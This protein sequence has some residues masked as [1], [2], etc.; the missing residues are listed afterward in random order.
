M[1]IIFESF[2]ACS[3]L[4]ILLAVIF[5]LRVNKRLSIILSYI[6][7]M[8]LFDE[9]LWSKFI[10]PCACFGTLRPYLSIVISPL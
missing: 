8:S 10:V 5:I 7:P 2:S 1:L 3:S 6:H 9:V 4:I